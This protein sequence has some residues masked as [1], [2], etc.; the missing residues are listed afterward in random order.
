MFVDLQPLT[1]SSDGFWVKLVGKR[2][3][4]KKI[5]VRMIKILNMGEVGWKVKRALEG[6]VFDPVQG[7]FR[8]SPMPRIHERRCW[9]C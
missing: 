1:N 7:Q 6:G 5:A 9:H 4:K 3:T 8:S 2:E